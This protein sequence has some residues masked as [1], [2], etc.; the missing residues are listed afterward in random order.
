MFRSA[1]WRN[2]LTKTF[3]NKE[4]RARTKEKAPKTKEQGSIDIKSII[5]VHL[6]SFQ[7]NSI[8]QKRRLSYQRSFVQGG[9]QSDGAQS[10]V[11][12]YHL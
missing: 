1:S 12:T 7:I 3:K 5:L 4:Q 8:V 2:Y 10:C 11:P 9:L 6:S